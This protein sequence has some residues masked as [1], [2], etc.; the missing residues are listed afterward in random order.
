M[1]MKTK[2]LQREYQRLWMKKRRDEFFKDKS[3]VKCGSKDNLELDHIDQSLKKN[4][5]DHRIWSWKE[6]RRIEEIKKCQVLCRE[7]HIEKTSIDNYGHKPYEHGT[8]QTYEARKCRC[9]QC[10]D[11]NRKR[12]LRTSRYLNTKKYKH[13]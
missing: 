3:C 7:C 12:Y 1:P 13:S 11:W 5:G 4:K 10:K 2:E 8:K 9:E 6:S